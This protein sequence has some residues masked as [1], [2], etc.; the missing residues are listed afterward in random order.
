MAA[1]PAKHFKQL[2]IVQ[3]GQPADIAGSRRVG[4]PPVKDPCNMATVRRIRAPGPDSDT[5]RALSA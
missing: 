3:L 2:M 5:F 4:H 1:D